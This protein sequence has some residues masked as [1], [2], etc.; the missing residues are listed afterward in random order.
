MTPPEK[1]NFIP[2]YQH[3]SD[4]A[5]FEMANEQLP[6]LDNSAIASYYSTVEA[7]GLMLTC[8]VRQMS[9]NQA[10]T[11]P[12]QVSKHNMQFIMQ[13]LER[14]LPVPELTSELRSRG[15]DVWSGYGIIKAMPEYLKENISK[16]KEKALTGSMLLFSGLAVKLLPLS[17]SKHQALIILVYTITAFGGIKWLDASFRIRRY[18]KMIAF[19]N[20]SLHKSDTLSFPIGEDDAVS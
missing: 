6:F 16:E 18:Q 13:S 10:I 4:E 11:K 17:S 14:R 5:L 2:Y 7:R 15:I 20:A 12:E 1:E 3:M 8:E 9:A 19:L